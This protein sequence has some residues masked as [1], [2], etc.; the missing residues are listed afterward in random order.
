MS[1]ITQKELKDILLYNQHTG[2]FTWKVYKGSSAK[3]G[4]IAG[5]VDSGGYHRVCI[6]YKTYRA[7]R[8]AFLYME[9]YFP[10][11]GID[12]INR[13]RDDNR[14][15]NLRE[16]NKQCNARNSKV[17]S[18][19]TS[20]VVG[21]CWQSRDVVWSSQI[22]VNGVWVYLGTFINFKDAV[23]ARWMAEVKYNFPTCNSTSSAYKYLMEHR[24]LNKIKN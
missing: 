13:I 17:P 3:K 16:A 22:T 7:H 12:H 14:W 11:N 4:S 24:I 2:L 19:N 18:D 20:G 8:L 6:N 10:E 9:G 5:S 1:D 15:C 23:L 21:V